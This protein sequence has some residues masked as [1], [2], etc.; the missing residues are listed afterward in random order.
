MYSKLKQTGLFK[1]GKKIYYGAQ[2]RSYQTDNKSAYYCPGCNKFWKS[3]KPI[4]QKWLKPL[5]ACGWPFTLDDAETLNY[6]NYT[7]YGC[8]ITDRDRLYILFFETFLKETQKYNVI[9]FAPTPSLSR[10]FKKRPNITHRTSDLFMDSVDDNL[11]IQDLHLYKDNSFDIF[12]CSHILEH[13]TDDIKAMKELY[14]IL[15]PGGVGIVMVPIVK[16][17][18]ETHEDPSLTDENL[19]MKYFGQG[20]HV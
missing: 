18:T 14:R 3:F 15:K 20:D 10:F 19:R 1:L 9:E 13:V 6:K 5:Y 4:P 17:V 2:K 12:I 8:G 7:C 16:P 11:D